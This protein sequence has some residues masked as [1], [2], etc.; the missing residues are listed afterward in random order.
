LV[1]Q[2]LLET[3]GGLPTIGTELELARFVSDLI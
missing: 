1:R 2:Q 3:P